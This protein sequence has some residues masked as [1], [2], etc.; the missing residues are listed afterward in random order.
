MP[1]YQGTKLPT[2]VYIIF[3]LFL[4]FPWTYCVLAT[5]SRHDGRQNCT[6]NQIESAH[7]PLTISDT[8]F[9]SVLTTSRNPAIDGCY[10][11]HYMLYRVNY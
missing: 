9:L 2:N 1:N 10:I 7:Q 5:T 8:A 4:I 11:L 6:K 3:C